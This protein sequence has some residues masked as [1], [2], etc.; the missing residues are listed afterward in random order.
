[1]AETLPL[2]LTVAEAAV[3]LGISDDTVYRYIA[4]GD[5]DVTDVARRGSVRA[6]NRVPRKS[7]E[8]FI[9]RRTRNAKKPL[10]TAS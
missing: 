7:I 4:D 8:A 3:A 2:L 9:A 1:M 6:K 5:L 10:R